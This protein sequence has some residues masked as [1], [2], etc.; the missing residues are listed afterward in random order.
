[1]AIYAVILLVDFLLFWALSATLN[2][3]SRNHKSFRLWQPVRYAI[4]CAVMELFFDVFCAYRF[5]MGDANAGTYAAFSW[6]LKIASGLVVF[7]NWHFNGQAPREVWPG[8]DNHALSYNVLDII[9]DAMALRSQ[10]DDLSKE[11]KTCLIIL[12]H[13]EKSNG[14]VSISKLGRE[15]LEKE[16]EDDTD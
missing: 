3:L 9:E 1:M 7:V 12:R 15:I 16:L 2:G 10:Q 13:L 6:L 8:L 4:G 11:L 5:L 14:R